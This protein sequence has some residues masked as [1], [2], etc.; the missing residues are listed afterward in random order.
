[1]HPPMNS[2]TSFNFT[3]AVLDEGTSFVFGSWVC[4]PDGAGSFC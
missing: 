1:M 3:S 2:M 4:V